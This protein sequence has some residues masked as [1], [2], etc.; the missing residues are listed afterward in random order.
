MGV[1][2]TPE[3][4][5]LTPEAVKLT[6]EEK[7]RERG[8]ERLDQLACPHT[9]RRARAH[10]QREKERERERGTH[11]CSLLGIVAHG[12]DVRGTLPRVCLIRSF[13]PWT[14][15]ISSKYMANWS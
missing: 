12:P 8:I 13:P 9:L 3:A 2:V 5:K 10:A 4:V 7:D 15:L 11:L 6:P 14:T 1:K